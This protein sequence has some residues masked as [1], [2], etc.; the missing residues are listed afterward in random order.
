MVELVREAAV[1]EVQNVE[2]LVERIEVECPDP[3]GRSETGG[4]TLGSKVVDPDENAVP[5]F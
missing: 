5:V 3:I 4:K 2:K 1:M